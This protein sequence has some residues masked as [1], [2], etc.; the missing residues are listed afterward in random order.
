MPYAKTHRREVVRL[1][2]ALTSHGPEPSMITDVEFNDCDIYGPAV[3]GILHDVAME[4]CTFDA[5]PEALFIEAQADRP[6]VGII[7]LS[8]VR[9]YDCRLHNV[10]VLGP[11][12]LLDMFRQALTGAGE[13]GSA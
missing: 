8:N 12:D 6:Y 5:P 2:E 4:S 10:G 1:H 13:P 3:V 9:L 7:G 11:P